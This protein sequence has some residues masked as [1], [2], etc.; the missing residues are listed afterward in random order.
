MALNY[1]VY[2][3]RTGRRLAFGPPTGAYGDTYG[4]PIFTADEFYA[5]L[6]HIKN[7]MGFHVYANSK[8]GGVNHSA[9]SPKS[10]HY[11]R[12]A[13]G[14]SLAADI[15]TYG[16]VNERTRIVNEL[17]PFLNRYGIAW[18]YARDGHVPGHW[19]H[20]HID[21]SNWGR[22]GGA[23]P[24]YGYFT[25]YRKR[26]PLELLGST[27]ASIGTPPRKR[28][29]KAIAI[30]Y[31]STDARG[32]RLVQRIVGIKRDG[33][34]GPATRNAVMKLQRSLGVTADGSF[35][36]ATARAYLAKYGAKGPGS[37]G[38]A[39][40]LIQYI[41]KVTIDGSYGAATTKAVKELQATAGLTPDGWFGPASRNKL[42]R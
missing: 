33:S 3:L 38:R 18:H 26:S 27:S 2:D 21:V 22:R 15:G 4:R 30:H 10:W 23:A 19:D 32:V 29:P 40:R 31:G 11:V 13:G 39:V 35:G 5:L 17:I 36:P 34:F 16:D 8:Y 41:A 20:I 25:T 14:R 28:T 42:I 1:A 6:D 37:R 24:N 12:A 7:K 9:H